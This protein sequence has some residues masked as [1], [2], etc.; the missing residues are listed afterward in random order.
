MDIID[1]EEQQEEY[2]AQQAD[3]RDAASLYRNRDFER[4]PDDSPRRCQGVT[5]QGQCSIIAVEGGTYCRLHGGF[6]QQRSIQARQLKNLRLNQFNERMS[7]LSNSDEIL[8]L[9]DEAAVLRMTLEQLLN[10]C[11]GAAD[12]VVNAPVISDLVMKTGK[13]VSDCA[14]IEERTGNLLSIDQVMQFASE[15]LDL[16]VAEVSDP[17]AQERIADKLDDLVNNI[18][19]TD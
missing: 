18:G 10:S 5:K 2:A 3:E 8:S 13:L 14:R 7:E 15:M 19:A 9:R 1:S 17:A 6:P 12:L 4:V 11:K 16:I